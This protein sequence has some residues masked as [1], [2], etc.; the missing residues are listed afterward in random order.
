MYR[1]MYVLRT[2]GAKSKGDF[3]ELRVRLWLT[4]IGESQGPVLAPGEGGRGR[5]AAGGEGEG[6]GGSYSCVSD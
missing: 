2:F 5:P 3:G 4:P 6:E 1:R